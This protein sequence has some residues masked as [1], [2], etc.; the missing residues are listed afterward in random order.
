MSQH[1]NV[2]IGCAGWSIPR[3]A[4]SKF[5]T[6][7]CHLNRYSQVFNSCEINSS[8]YRFH[9][10]PTWERWAISVPDGFQFSVKAP[11][12]ITHEARLRCSSET[13][14]DFFN[15]ASL[16]REKLGPI[17]VQLP[18]S[19][20]FVPSVADKFLLTLRGYYAGD[21][22][23]EPRHYSWFEP[24]ADELFREY[25]IARVAADPACVPRASYPGGSPGLAYFRLH[26]SPRQY[27][28]AYSGEYLNMLAPT[29]LD[30]AVTTKVWCIFDNT[31]S[32][33]AIQNALELNKTVAKTLET[34]AD[35][36]AERL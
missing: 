27:Y 22:A 21:V 1:S 6:V 16:L 10:K 15:Q 30:L 24:R 32:G 8:F 11:K 13:L 36:Q 7:G 35:G 12:N 17:L 34:G 5:D 4:M 14:S 29:L 25:Q 33:S 19:L 28:S 3:V 31:A 26:G 18:P 20:E 23:W 9:K 2:R